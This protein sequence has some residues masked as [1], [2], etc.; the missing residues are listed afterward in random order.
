MENQVNLIKKIGNE[1]KLAVV[2][3]DVIMTLYVLWLIVTDTASWIPGALF[4]FT[5]F[6][7]WELLRA[8]KLFHLCIIHKL[9]IWHIFIVYCCCIF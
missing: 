7:V 3:T 9:M 1:I 8:N 2:H 6:G 4:G 5:P